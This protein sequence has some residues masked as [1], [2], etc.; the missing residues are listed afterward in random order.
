MPDNF[1]CNTLQKLIAP[2]T[3]PR[4]SFTPPYASATFEA[5][6]ISNIL[7]SLLMPIY[8]FAETLSMPSQLHAYLLIPNISPNAL[9]NYTLAWVYIVHCSTPCISTAR[10]AA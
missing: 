7:R 6:A 10:P 2:S 4:A 8:I 5:I 3:S 9:L 1:Y